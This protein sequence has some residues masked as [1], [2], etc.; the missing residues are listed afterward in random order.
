MKTRT[1]RKSDLNM[2]MSIKKPRRTGYLVEFKEALTKSVP[3]FRTYGDAIRIS[4]NKVTHKI[5]LRDRLLTVVGKSRK[6]LSNEFA[7]Q[8][9]ANKFYRELTGL[10]PME[11]TRILSNEDTKSIAMSMI[12]DSAKV[13]SIRYRSST[14]S[15]IRLRMLLNGTKGSGEVRIE[16][17][18]DSLTENE[19]SFV[20]A[21][22]LRVIYKNGVISRVTHRIRMIGSTIIVN[23]TTDAPTDESEFQVNL[24]NEYKAVEYWEKYV[25]SK[26]L[27]S[28]STDIVVEH[29][30]NEYPEIKSGMAIKLN[31]GICLAVLSMSGKE[32]GL[33]I[34][35]DERYQLD[36][37][38]LSKKLDTE[39]DGKYLS[40]EEIRTITPGSDLT[41][42]NWSSWERVWTKKLVTMAFRGKLYN[43]EQFIETIL[44]MMSPLNEDELRLIR[45]DEHNENQ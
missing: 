20:R 7:T 26:V 30:L 17:N 29:D 25:K 16:D 38:K 8:S 28:P 12:P 24:P 10:S 9:E 42:K 19:R 40:V 27:S 15:G 33:S 3:E 34:M 37:S 4:N 41:F 1:A 21:Q 43:K 22:V 14:D 13:R 6:I 2:I 35:D 18:L 32:I 23:P 39:I 44:T 31:N 11:N 5:Q 45:R 36:I